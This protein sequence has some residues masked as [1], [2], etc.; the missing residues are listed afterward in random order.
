VAAR[1]E[2]G[3]ELVGATEK[4]L[5]GRGVLPDSRLVVEEVDGG[6]VALEGLDRGLVEWGLATLGRGDD[7]LG[8]G[9]QD[10]VR[11]GEFGLWLVSVEVTITVEIGRR[12]R[13]QP[14]GLPVVVIL[15]ADVRTTRILGAIVTSLFVLS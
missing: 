10:I 11:V 7:N 12:T 14:V 4:L 5:E 3:V 9:S 2:E 8:L 1:V 15:S 13:Y 6:L